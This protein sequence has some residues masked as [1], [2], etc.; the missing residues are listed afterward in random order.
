MQKKSS[1]SAATIIF[2]LGLVLGWGLG[3]GFSTSPSL[4]DADLLQQQAVQLTAIEQ[5]LKTVSQ[6]LQKSRKNEGQQAHRRTAT[7][8]DEQDLRHMI[9]RVIENELGNGLRN[10]FEEFGVQNGNTLG[11]GQAETDILNT[12][13][14]INAYREAQDLVSFAI[15]E[16]V[17]TD[18]DVHELRSALPHLTTEQRTE[19]LQTII[20]A[21]NAGEIVV[22]SSGPLL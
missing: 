4:S 17:W 1:F 14:N 10:V 3:A 19:V 12:P 9:A 16:G 2:S 20:P 6:T 5:T 7:T 13:E 22:E 18:E 8:L 11:A 21:I 15:N